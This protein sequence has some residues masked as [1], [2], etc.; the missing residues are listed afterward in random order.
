MRQVSG[1]ATLGAALLL[2]V[3][4]LAVAPAQ[5][6]T[7]A[8]STTTLTLSTTAS[9]FGQTVTAS[10]AVAT[11]PGPAEGDVVF[12][13]DGLAYKANLGGS[14]TAT[15]VLPRAGVGQHAV[16]ATFVP[17][18]ALQQQ[19]SASAALPWAVAPAR[20][21]LQARAV[22]KGLRIPT[23]LAIT[24]SGD[25]GTTPRG[26]VGVGLRRAGRRVDSATATLTGTVLRVGFGR[27]PRGRY[28]AV[29]R[30][31]GDASHLPAQRVVRFRVR[32]R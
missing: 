32:Q 31:R 29:V 15:L 8:P 11:S 20:T 27:L 17:A 28:R 18:D 6:A 13:V 24:V 4:S 12:A 14:G 16:T 7:A 1:T 3:A 19:G 2:G 9:A 5:A 26:E 10:A 23:Y 21:R 25:F 30:Y 22:G